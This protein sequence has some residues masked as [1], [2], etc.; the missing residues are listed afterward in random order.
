MR[1]VVATKGIG[2][3]NSML[4]KHFRSRAILGHWYLIVF[5]DFHEHDMNSMMVLWQGYA[6]V[7]STSDARK[8]S[9][10]M[11]PPG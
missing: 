9:Q 6:L 11:D 1:L 7:V 3:G 2:I 10:G 5:I 4:V 8:P